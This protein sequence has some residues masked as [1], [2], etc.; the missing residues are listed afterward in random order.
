[1]I[2]RFTKL[3]NKNKS[4]NDT[5]LQ[6][7]NLKDLVETYNNEVDELKSYIQNLEKE[8]KQLKKIKSVS[9][10]QNQTI[11]FLLGQALINTINKKSPSKELPSTLLDIYVES[12]KRK[13]VHLKNASL[14][15]KLIILS[16]DKKLLEEYSLVIP[17]T[18]KNIQN[19]VSPT[20]KIVDPAEALKAEALKAEALKTETKKSE[21]LAAKI[22]SQNSN[23]LTKNK[24]ISNKN[25]W[26]QIDRIELAH[27]EPIWCTVTVKEGDKINIKAAVEYLNIENVDARK[28]AVLLIKSLDASETEINE[29]C[30]KLAYSNSLN[31][32][33]KYLLCTR[34]RVKNLHTFTAPKGVVSVQVGLCGFGLREKEQI[35]VRELSVKPDKVDLKTTP[36]SPPS[37]KAAQISII[38]WPEYPPSDKPY[39]MG[40][41]DEFT[42]G[43][44]ENDINLIQPRPD[45]WYALAEKYPPSMIFIE[46]AWKG[47]NA[48]WQ[49]RVGQY[50]TKPGQEIA[51]LCQYAREKGI[52]TVFWNKEDPVHHDKFMCSAKL[53]DYIFTT[54]A[55]MRESYEHKTGNKK[56]HALPFAAQPALH[57]P[58]SL[59]GRKPLC[60]FAGSWYGNR[61]EE[62]GTA[63]N[64]LLQAANKYGLEIYDRNYGS[65]N[66]VF[67]DEFSAGIKGSLSYKDLCKE[68][69]R[70]RVF[71][72][73]NSVTDSPTM[74]SRRVFELM[75]TGTPVVSTYAKGIENLFDSDAV[76]IVHNQKEAEE[77]IH[78]LLTNDDEW[79][80]RSLAGIREI[81]T[82]HTYA[83]RLN[84]I[85]EKIGEVSRLST[86]PAILLIASASS[87]EE[88]LQ[89]NEMA[90]SQVYDEFRLGI[91]YPKDVTSVKIPLSDKIELL[92]SGTRKGW[93]IGLHKSYPITGWVSPDRKYGS[94]YLRD[95]ANASIYEPTA[96]GWAKAIDTDKFAYGEVASLSGTIWKA[97]EFLKQHVNTKRDSLTK[98]SR[99]YIVDSDEFQ[100]GEFVEK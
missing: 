44:F 11:S 89:L 2:K 7:D 19:L 6:V 80:R 12:R 97:S 84:Y 98:Q 3:L 56:V 49:Y 51:H 9:S 62:R 25:I 8:N 47:N 17:P 41:M 67:P 64:W 81:F 92:S 60:C 34:N 24:L 38:G 39:V 35:F 57:K 61:H 78:T 45:N 99:L 26:N 30:G 4:S 1:M 29:P 14:I 5:D 76:W 23:T 54:D 46:S 40:I 93:I 83:H 100:H 86:N 53:V 63:M 72:N 73:V 69:S 10:N 21:A 65:G 15:D 70:Y 91:E 71:L 43:S 90:Q 68:Y 96:I 55:N 28:A 27:N 20:M 74:F 52:P 66:F 58:A 48:S 13:Y 22:T 77:A 75:A 37:I 82:Q 42:T 32:Y 88:L 16:R 31:S 50:A 94:Y 33:F 36:F 59:L 85:F 79:R 87:E 18:K 95:L